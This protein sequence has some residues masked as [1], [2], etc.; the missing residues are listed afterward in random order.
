MNIQTKTLAIILSSFLVLTLLLSL[1]LKNII[2]KNYLHL[3]QT[4]VE[5]HLQRAL[6]IIEL[7]QDNLQQ[8]TG[9]WAIWDDTFKFI[10]NKN[11]EYIKSNLVNSTFTDSDIAFIAYVKKSGEIVYGRAYDQNK[12]QQ[13]ALPNGLLTYLQREKKL[14]SP[15]TAE[16]TITGL[17]SL[18]AGSFIISSFAILTS[19]VKGPSP[20]V[21]IIGRRFDDKFISKLSKIIKI[22]AKIH[23]YNSTLKAEL[24]NFSQQLNINNKYIS[25]ASNEEKIS[26]YTFIYDINNNPILLFQLDIERAIYQQG[27]KTANYILLAIII[28]IIVTVLVIFLLMR[29]LILK[30]ISKLSKEV[31]NIQTSKNISKRIT[32]SSNDEIS[33]LSRNINAMLSSIQ[34]INNDL[35]NSRKSAEDANQAKSEFLSRMNHELRT[36]LNAILG[37]SQLLD[38]DNK[39]ISSE[40]HKDN[41]NEITI[42]GNY[43]LKL[44]NGLLDLATIEER[45]YK[46]V[47]IDVNIGDLIKNCISMLSPL[48]NEKDIALYNDVP[49]NKEFI[50]QADPTSLKQILINLINNAIKYNKE[51]GQVHI[52]CAYTPENTLTI[53]VIDTGLGIPPSELENI[54]EPFQRINPSINI[55]GTGIGLAVTKKLIG[56]MEGNIKVE[57]EFGMGCRFSIELP[58]LNAI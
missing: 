56:L 15:K 7:E 14:L 55:E 27:K 13:T 3:E 2:T 22:D 21:L 37:F 32:E 17:I 42:A 41:I 20:G 30:R 53:F 35:E 6:N 34:D 16:E 48:A 26:G 29:T 24:K 40:M 10:Q 9:D 58:T 52:E 51:N 25:L 11:K 36:P 33:K 19:N 12:E 49:H 47:I 5:N 1:M 44:I 50:A 28:I 46:Q 4:E 39:N 38:I 18:P 43:L 31:N 45:N 54:F 8:F 57:S 23:F